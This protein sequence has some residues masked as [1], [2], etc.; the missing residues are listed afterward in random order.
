MQS[1]VPEL[2]TIAQF[3]RCFGVSRTALYRL[4]TSGELNARKIGRRTVITR[5]D[6]ERWV[7]ALP[8]ANIKCR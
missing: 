1:E 4:L 3:V 6:A 5:Y 2:Y 8:P 7:N